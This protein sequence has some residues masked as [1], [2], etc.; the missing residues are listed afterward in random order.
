M[1]LRS[2]QALIDRC[3][4]ALRAALKDA[5]L[6][7][8]LGAAKETLNQ[9]RIAHEEIERLTT[10]LETSERERGRLRGIM[11]EVADALAEDIWLRITECACGQ[12]ENMRLSVAKLRAALTPPPAEEP[13]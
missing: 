13:I 6:D 4:V 3:P 1:H 11:R 12:C 2:R 9:L 7:L 10:K 8:K 5:E